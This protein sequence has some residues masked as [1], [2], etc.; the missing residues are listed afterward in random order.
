MEIPAKGLSFPPEYSFRLCNE[1]FQYGTLCINAFIVWKV[2][3]MI[4]LKNRKNIVL[5]GMAACGKSTIGAL[6]AKALDMTFI[7]TDLIMQQ[8]YGKPLRQLLEDGGS[9]DFILKESDAFCSLECT[10]SCI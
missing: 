1:V 5:I 3:F 8:M 7:D 9:H 6:L 10:N 2:D 4:E